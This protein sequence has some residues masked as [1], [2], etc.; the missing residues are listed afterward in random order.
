LTHVGLAIDAVAENNGDSVLDVE[1]PSNRPDC[2]SHIGIAREVAVI[3]T[4]SVRLPASKPA[5]TKGKAAAATA[6]EIVDANLCPRYSARLIRSVKIGPSPSWL[7][8]RLEEIGQRPINNVADVTN[9]VLHEMGQPLHAFDFAKLAEQRVVVRRAAK[10]EKLKTLDG[11]ERQLDETMLV[12]ADAF[13][14]SRWPELWGAKTR[15]FPPAPLT[16]SLR[17]RISIPTLCGRRHGN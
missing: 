17:V 7:A 2:L 16:F 6:V 13:N 12:I 11:V 5:P 10:H 15:R 14:P 1:V 4:K 3:E 9:Y 8:K